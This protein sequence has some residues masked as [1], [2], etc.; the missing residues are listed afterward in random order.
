MDLVAIVDA[1]ADKA[2]A[3]TGLKGTTGA[4]TAIELPETPW[5]VVYPGDGSATQA[6]ATM[7][8][9]ELE[10]R[11]YVPYGQMPDAYATLLAFP[12]RFEQAWRSGR[13]LGGLVTDSWYG[14]HGRVAREDWPNGVAYASI[15]I[16]IG[17][18]A[19]AATDLTT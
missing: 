17:L 3:I 10:V 5:A 1:V 9:E 4:R 12:A 18:L 15:T 2:A 16:R 11:V 14:G 7:F 19:D 13:S 6:T 8:S